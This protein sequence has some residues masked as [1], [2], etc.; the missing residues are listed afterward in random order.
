MY[1]PQALW[2]AANRRL[3][4]LFVV[5]DN[6][7]YAVL[8]ETLETWQGRS[9]QMGDYVALDLDEPRLDF[10]ALASSMGVLASAVR[11][12]PEAHEAARAAV[13]AGE[14]RLLHVPLRPA[15]DAA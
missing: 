14:P 1:S 12:P 15:G 7:G 6:R 8:R 11:S 13:A 10:C 5:M 4:I 3:P 9:A 2:T